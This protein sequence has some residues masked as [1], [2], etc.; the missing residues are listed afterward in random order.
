M[1]RDTGGSHAAA[2]APIPEDDPAV[3]PRRRLLSSMDAG[4]GGPS[5]GNGS[6]SNTGSA[7]ASASSTGPSLLDRLNRYGGSTRVIV[8]LVISIVAFSYFTQEYVALSVSGGLALCFSF[9]GPPPLGQARSRRH[10]LTCF[11]FTLHK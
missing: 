8:A 9:L 2:V 6:S 11:F 5:P 1:P 3:H 4:A 10:R 7:S